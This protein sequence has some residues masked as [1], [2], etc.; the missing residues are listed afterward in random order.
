MT[1]IQ[2]LETWVFVMACV[3]IVFAELGVIAKLERQSRL[4][5]LPATQEMLLLQDQGNRPALQSAPRSGGD[6]E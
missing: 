4:A 1:I 5:S 6:R 3:I 2:K